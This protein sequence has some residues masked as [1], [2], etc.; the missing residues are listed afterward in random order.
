MVA[1][2]SVDD[3]RKCMGDPEADQDNPILKN[4]QDAQVSPRSLNISSIR[5]ILKLNRMNF[6]QVLVPFNFPLV[7]LHIESVY[8]P[9]VVHA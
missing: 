4:E 8:F 5:V 1:A 6:C 7:V 3:V 2:I 9:R